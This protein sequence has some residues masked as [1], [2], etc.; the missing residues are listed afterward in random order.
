MIFVTIVNADRFRIEAVRV[1]DMQSSFDWRGALLI[2]AQD[3]TG[4]LDKGWPISTE[5][6]AAVR[7]SD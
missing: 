1:A 7:M 6:Q 3:R 2:R 4:V 5:L